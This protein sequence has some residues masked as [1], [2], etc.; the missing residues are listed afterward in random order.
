MSKYILI[1]LM[2]MILSGCLS[3]V[4]IAQQ[5]ARQAEARALQAQYEQETAR[6]QV[7]ADASKP[8]Q[9]PIVFVSLVFCTVLIVVVYMMMRAQ[10][11]QTAMLTGQR[12]ASV[13]LLPGQSQFEKAL[14]E[15]AQERG[16]RPIRDQR[17]GRYYLPL[18][19]GGREEVKAIV[20]DG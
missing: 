14:L 3:D 15:M 2:T 6:F 19:D 1:I 7:L 10:I 11:Q 9:W 20:I 16:V 5:N 8:S 13:R 12:S 17:G 18:S 4:E